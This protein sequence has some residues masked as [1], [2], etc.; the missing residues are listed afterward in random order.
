MAEDNKNKTDKP[1][2]EKPHYT[3]IDY[4]KNCRY[5]LTISR[6]LKANLEKEALYEGRSLNNYII[7]LINSHPKRP[8]VETE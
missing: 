3:T 2:R 5:L 6:E 1:K 7:Y 4:D 8:K